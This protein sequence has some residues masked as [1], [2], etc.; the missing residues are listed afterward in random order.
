MEKRGKIGENQLLCLL[1]V[2]LLVPALRLFPT[3]SAKLSGKSGWISALIALPV[4]LIYAAFLSKMSS[5]CRARSLNEALGG[6][7][8]RFFSLLFSLWFT[9]YAAFLLRS[10][11]QRLVSAIYFESPPAFFSLTMAAVC[12]FA[13]SCSALVLARFAKLVLPFLGAVLALVLVFS[14]LSA[15]ASRLGPLTLYSLSDAV[16][17]AVAALDVICAIA[18]TKFFLDRE[19]PAGTVSGR[20]YA[21][22]VVLAS[23]LLAA[24][25]IALLGNLGVGLT[26]RLSLPFFSL[27]QSLTFFGSVER[28][29]ALVVAMWIFPD[30][31]FVSVLL[32]C[33][34]DLLD[35]VFL[36]AR[37]SLFGV[38]GSLLLPSLL[39]AVLSCLLA[40][41]PAALT[42]WSERL[43]PGINLLFSFVVMPVLFLFLRRKKRP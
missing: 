33:A 2:L 6:R 8:G 19:R 7:V 41:D 4:G 39:S 30:M 35:S 31:L 21:L 40:R 12:L 24:L 1:F 13:A 18:V 32:H 29:E 17:G 23:L 22:W 16:P 37:F 26:G 28:V 20:G 43:I 25:D 10:G 27:V 14:L 38:S 11:S 36:S 3:A 5:L 15:D 42:L 34:A 9:L